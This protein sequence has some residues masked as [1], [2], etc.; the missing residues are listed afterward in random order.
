MAARLKLLLAEYGTLLAIVLLV[1]A[2]GM[3]GLAYQAYSDPPSETMTEEY[4]IEQYDVTSETVA[5]VNGPDPILYEP[6][7]EL[8]DMPA[9][10]YNETP[11][12]TIVA[13]LDTPDDTTVDVSARM[14]I[15]YE[16]ERNDVV[17]WE[18]TE[19]LTE[20]AT[21]VDDGEL[22][23]EA[24]HDMQSA[25]GATTEVQDRI[26]GVGSIDSFVRLHLEYESDHYE[27]V[28]TSESPVQ[29]G[30]QAYWLEDELT[31]STTESQTETYTVVQDPPMGEVI[32]LAFIGLLLVI[33]SGAIVTTL[34]RGIDTE[35]LQTELARSEHDEWISRG[36]IPTRGEKEFVA[37]DSLVDLVDI[38]I[39]SNKRVIYDTGI[40]TYA[41]V[42]GD[43]IYYY[44][45]SREDVEEWFGV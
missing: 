3:F 43:I 36:E 5:I 24:T 30:S 20:E 9:Y 40:D 12:L 22:R 33:G 34:Y 11:E 37:I 45:P 25:A 41:V 32:G 23:I 16:A 10:F 15:E 2:A 7:E 4:D 35:Q 28:L 14:T 1:A 42:E 29:F 6:G 26:G 27:G 8:V 21:T 18:Q 13:I 31:A 19:L 39:D 17:F 44:S 38:A